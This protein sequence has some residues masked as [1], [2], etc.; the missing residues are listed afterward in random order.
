MPK[1]FGD[2]LNE[3]VLNQYWRHVGSGEVYVVQI[4]RD[5]DPVDVVISACGPLY[6][7]DVTEK[8]LTDWNFNNDPEL[9]QQLNDAPDDVYALVEPPYSG[10][11]EQIDRWEDEVATQE[12]ENARSRSI[13][14]IVE[15]H[16]DE[17]A[18]LIQ[19]NLYEALLECLKKDYPNVAPEQFNM[20]DVL[21]YANTALQN[22]V[23]KQ[24]GLFLPR[25]VLIDDD[26]E[27]TYLVPSKYRHR[28]GEK[29]T[30]SAKKL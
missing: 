5:K 19:P 11:Q 2:G 26:F 27:E 24:I 14:P 18:L 6:Y 20:L 30:E 21:A 9:R 25:V 7:K 22:H 15:K 28:Q 10:D 23:E 12:R 13:P 16:Q 3:N 29:E 1:K 8:N 17:I 4:G